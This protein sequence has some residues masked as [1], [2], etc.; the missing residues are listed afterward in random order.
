MRS[1]SIG[2]LALA[3]VGCGR[4]GFGDAPPDAGTEILADAPPACAQEPWKVERILDELTSLASTDWSPAWGLGTELIVFESDRPGGAGDSDLYLG[5][6]D[7]STGRYSALRALTEVN[8]AARESAPTLS[9][10]GL[11]LFFNRGADILRTTRGST[12]A[13]FGAASVVIPGAFGADLGNRDLDLIYTLRENNRTRFVIRSRPK[14]GATDFGAPRL[15]DE[16]E[17]DNRAGWPSLAHDGLELYYEAGDS[18]PTHFSH[19]PS[20]DARFTAPLPLTELGN[21]SDPDI[22]NDGQWLLYIS[23]DTTYVMMARRT[24]LTARTRR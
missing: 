5:R 21:A 13:R 6:L 7:A 11:E 2:W 4:L 24:C 19:R 1:G 14:A 15:L 16:L 10:D 9:Q 3:A 22:S 17:L 23:S 12:T 20:L 18:L 8:T